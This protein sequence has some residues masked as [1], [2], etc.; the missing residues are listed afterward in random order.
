MITNRE[1]Y[2]YFIGKISEGTQR[3]FNDKKIKLNKLKGLFLTGILD[4]WSQVGGLPGLFLTLSD[5][6]K[7]DV[8]VFTNNGKV[9]KYIVACWR[10]FVFRKGVT[11]NVHDVSEMPQG[12]YGDSNM[13]IKPVRIASDLYVETPP[14][15]SEITRQLSKLVSLMFPLDTSEV[16]SQDPESYKSD[17]ADKD[18]QTHVSIEDFDIELHSKGQKALSYL[19]EFLPI[20]GKFDVVKAKELG[21]KPGLAFKDLSN[22]IPVLN[23]TNELIQPHQ[24]V[25]ANKTFP[26]VLVLDIPSKEYLKNTLQYDWVTQDEDSEAI[27][28]VYHLLGDDI[29]FNLEQY[30]QFI[31][32]FPL[33]CRH[34]VSHSK[35]GDN[36]LVFKTFSIHLLKLRSILSTYFN[37]PYSEPFQPLNEGP[38]IKLHQLQTFSI[39]PEAISL[40]DSQIFDQSWS[41]IYEE[42]IV[43]LKLENAIKQ[44]IIDTTPLSLDR[45]SD[46]IKDNVQVTTLGTGSALPALHR[47][48]ISNLVR[49]PFEVSGKIY[50]KSVMFDGGENTLGSLL[51]TFGHQQQYVRI[52]QEL[53]L[54]Y[55]SHLHADH[56][57]GL[58]SIINKWF[59]VNNSNTKV[60]HIVS[61]WQYD[62][63]LREWYKLE[64]N[65]IDMA[66]INYISCED[67]MRGR[68]AEYKKID[69]DEFEANFDAG[70][71]KLEIA[72]D[73]LKPI[74]ENAINKLYEDLNIKELSTCRAIHCYWA[75]SVS[76][77]FGLNNTEDFKVS[78]SGDTRPNS[79]FVDIG[80]NSDLLIHES[81]LDNTLI[82]EAISKKH[83]TMVEAI[84]VARFMNCP[85]L[86]LTH[87]STRYSNRANFLSS[88]EDFLG[89]SN[90]LREYLST[91][92][93][94]T[95]IYQMEETIN[96]PIKQFSELEILFAFDTL[97]TRVDQIK[98]QKPLLALMSQVLEFESDPDNEKELAKQRIKRE[99]K[100]IQRLELQKKRKT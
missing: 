91:Y 62:H 16:N 99:S 85:R 100:R 19:I 51:R 41:E 12:V 9:L 87:F 68:L 29:D 33:N 15:S 31:N 3:V 76:I 84:N 55:L 8:D 80:Y 61:P 83:S 63:F 57:L 65:A 92:T 28:L 70:N 74:N 43:P 97:I 38:F 14:N 58:I 78:Y 96:I 2:R 56:H 81:S 10:Y 37:L 94:I 67:F 42:N 39:S 5:A 47:N 6:T 93:G 13:I 36:T 66:R 52:F 90:E 45:V 30:I 53:S 44:D 69:I 86:I 54:I 49:I 4:S 89:L 27:G 17:P 82:E 32:L 1:G 48:V 11:I 46:N 21:I 18:L 22:G 59:E 72:R 88:Q 71:T 64:N 25:G 98:Q 60:L 50:Y 73:N 34:V 26:K 7:K 75:Y 20:R 79:K 24:V 35:L 40:D 77:T 23:D 95:N